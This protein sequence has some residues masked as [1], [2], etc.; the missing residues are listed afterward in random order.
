MKKKA[1]KGKKVHRAKARVV[2]EGREAIGRMKGKAALAGAVGVA[3]V[4]L[5]GFYLMLIPIN[6]HAVNFWMLLFAATAVYA[7]LYN[8]IFRMGC[9]AEGIG[10]AGE[11]LYAYEQGSLRGMKLFVI[12]GL[13][14][15]AVI[16]IAVSGAKMFHAS[17]YASVLQIEDAVFEEDLAETLNTDSIAL[18]DTQS[19]Q[20]LGDREIGSLSGVVSQYNVSEDYIQIDHNGK[21]LK[22]AA[23]DYA[24]FFKW[25]NNRGEGVPGYVSVDPVSMSASYQECGEG[26]IYVPSAYFRQ[27]AARYMW[28][29]F[30]T[31]IL[32]NLHFEI[33]EEGEPYYIA[34][35]YEKTI[36]LFGG[37][38]V[39]GAVI[40]N[41]VDGQIEYLDLAD[42]PTWVDVVYDGDLICAQYNW[43]GQLQN[44]FINSIF[45]KKGCKRVTTYDASEEEEES[46]DAVPLS[47]YGYVSK[48]GDIWIYTGITSV[49]GDSSN[50]GFILGN[51]RTGETHYYEIAGADEKS[52][53]AAAEGEVQEKGYQA[54]FPSL[55]NVDGEPTYIMVLKDDSGLV[56]LYAAVNVEQYNLVATASRQDDCI[57]KY[58]EL[59]GTADGAAGSE[60]GTDSEADGAEAEG[61]GDETAVLEPTGESTVTIADIKYIDI[62]GNTYLYLITDAREIYRA[63]AADHEEM[64][65][66]NPGDQVTISY[67]EKE[68]LT[69]RV[70]SPQA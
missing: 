26:M 36:S 56:K 19:A 6:L 54:S 53:M 16:V 1:K 32:G 62:D 60:D 3:V 47:D 34:S 48:D 27:D 68:I 7:A 22:V 23:L 39:K 17:S 14:L 67:H 4:L 12:P 44:G 45:G 30:P 13:I 37:N 40:L 43:H 52:A 25:R 18:M 51:E 57:E 15:A 41:P 58:R 42:V 33:N 64:L 9:A 5:V 10:Q 20:M 21:P 8:L 65:L 59:I 69:C 31:E 11:E 66:L 35:V 63:K 70:N 29:H 38:T 61:S 24:G 49:N 46:G 28:K 55:I 50:I 2:P